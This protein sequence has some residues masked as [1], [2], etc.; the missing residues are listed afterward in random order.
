MLLASLQVVQQSLLLRQANPTIHQAKL[1]ITGLKRTCMVYEAVPTS[2][3]YTSVM[4]TITVYEL[5]G[6]SAF[7]LTARYCET[8][9]VVATVGLLRLTFWQTQR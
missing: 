6:S 5:P 8:C 7:G 2:P 9:P 4:Y 1:T 3:V